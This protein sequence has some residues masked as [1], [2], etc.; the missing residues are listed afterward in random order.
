MVCTAG[1]NEIQMRVD[2]P[3]RALDD[4]VAPKIG[5]VTLVV[6]DL[7]KAAADL[8]RFF[9]MSFV[10]TDPAGL[11]E[12]A[13]VGPHRVKLVEKPSQEMIRHFEMPLAAIE[14][15]YDDVEET[16][17]RLERAGYPVVHTR[18]LKSGN[19]YSFGSAFQKIGRAPSEPQSLMRI[20]YAVFCFKKK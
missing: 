7:G 17:Q 20:S 4:A 14:F 19:A 16:R 12:R 1:D 9:D 2:G 11:G 8:G 18:K 6:D 5:C 3:F 13:L 15:M 10:E